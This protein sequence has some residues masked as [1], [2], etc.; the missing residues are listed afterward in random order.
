MSEEDDDDDEEEGKTAVQADEKIKNN[1]PGIIGI[2]LLFLNL[3][4]VTVISELCGFSKR[5]NANVNSY[6]RN[7]F[8]EN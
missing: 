6:R 4:Y 7:G 5:G 3:K 1:K 8:T 2:I